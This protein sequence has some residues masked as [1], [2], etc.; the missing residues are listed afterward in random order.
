M[1]T[2]IKRMV[3]AYSMTFSASSVVNIFLNRT[4]INRFDQ[5]YNEFVEKLV[6]DSPNFRLGPWP[7]CFY[8]PKDEIVRIM[9]SKR[10][11]DAFI[12]PFTLTLLCNR[13][14]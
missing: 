8:I 6:F 14:A 12:D 1:K 13:E 5:I 9:H 3:E 2:M 10:Q 7:N 11:F 4:L